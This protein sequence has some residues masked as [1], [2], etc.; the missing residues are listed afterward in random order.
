MRA[1]V[2]VLV[3][4]ASQAEYYP[5]AIRALDPE[6]TVTSFRAR[7]DA[8]KVMPEADIL[9][10]FGAGLGTDFFRDARRLK[11][12]HA[13]G[14][15]LD[16]ITDS[17]FLDNRVLVT[18][19]R[20]IHGIPMSEAAIMM[21]LTLARDFR[22][23]LRQQEARQWQFF[24]AQLL[25]G[26][27]VGIL[28]IGAIASHVAERCKAMG[29]TVVG[30]TRTV[31]DLPG[32]DR[33]VGRGD[34]LRIVPELD[35]LILLIPHDAD[36]HHIVDARVLAVMKPTSFLI[37]LARGGVIDETAL[38]AALSEKRIAGAAL[39]AYEHEPLPPDSPLWGLPN[40]ICSPHMTGAWDGYAQACFQQ[41]AFNYRQFV[42]GHPERMTYLEPRR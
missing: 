21:M 6:L 2:V 20:G 15:G 34:L 19:T 5:K 1:N 40:V 14:T 17:V 33:M 3:H 8:L 18:A 10:S 41:F 9:L 12:V 32:F 39:D 35:F 24:F 25:H 26:K 4:I 22:R 23:T 7:D 37:N 38:V 36:S 29:M 31:R 13:L 28:G 11:W 30:I 27:T 16:G 42:A